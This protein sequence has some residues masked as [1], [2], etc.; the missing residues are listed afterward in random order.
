MQQLQQQTGG[1]NDLP[2]ELLQLIGFS[3]DIPSL[4]QFC[5]VSRFLSKCLGPCLW[6][7]IPSK[8]LLSETFVNQFSHYH[9]HIRHLAIRL[10][11]YH[12][13]VQPYFD[14]CLRGPPGGDQKALTVASSTSLRHHLLVQQSHYSIVS[15]SNPSV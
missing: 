14:L 12:D 5:L 13:Q 4:L 1:L 6:R 11:C 2:I 8:A 7:D 3:L 10:P 9:K 15:V